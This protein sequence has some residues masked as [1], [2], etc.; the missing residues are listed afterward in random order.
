MRVQL[1]VFAVTVGCS[2][3][4]SNPLV[5]AHR[6][7]S[8]YWPQNSASAVNGTLQSGFQGIEVDLGLTR[9]GVAILH[10]DPFLESPSCS[11]ANGSELSERVRLDQIRLTRIQ[12]SYLC[13][14]WADP[15]FPDAEV[16]A[17]P[18]MSFPEFLVMLQGASSELQ[19]HL[20]V[21]VE[22]G[23]TRPAEDFAEAIL[24]PWWDSELPQPLIVTAN[25]SEALVA[26]EDH[27]RVHGR[28]LTTLLIHPFAAVDSSSV[29][30]GLGSER[31][32]LLGKADYIALIEQSQADGIAVN[33]EVAERQQLVWAQN[34]GWLTALWTVNEGRDLESYSK[35]PVDILI[36]DYP[37]RW[38]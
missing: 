36:S 9:D 7:G 22:E 35:W 23:W 25:T 13:G 17:E 11:R 6:A 31:D 4:P 8:G 24:E 15:E 14:G 27:A 20:D 12:D 26:F 2:A 3:G 29:A 38:R 19:V 16:V 28:D 1:L 34:A 37:A 30:V 10:H 21:K 33:F 5:E 18:L 32:S